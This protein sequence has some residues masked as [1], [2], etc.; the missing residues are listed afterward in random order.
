MASPDQKLFYFPIATWFMLRF[1]VSVLDLDN[2]A[3]P[4]R[5]M[6]SYSKAPATLM[7][8]LSE[9]CQFVRLDDQTR[10]ARLVIK[11]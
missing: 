10:R 4:L 3:V 8:Y 7:L 5:D 6:P 1:L 11:P 2:V 9:R